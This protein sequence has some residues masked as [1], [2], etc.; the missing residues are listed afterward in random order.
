MGSEMCIRDSQQRY[1]TIELE[2][3]AIMWA[4]IK[5]N[6]YLKGLPHFSVLTDHKPLEGIFTKT[7]YELSNPRLRRRIREKVSGYTFSV[8]WVAGKT[9]YIADALS[10]APLF[11]PEDDP[12]M[13]VD[14]ALTALAITDD[15]AF[16]IIQ[17]NIDPD[18]IQCMNDIM[19][20]TERSSLIKKLSNIRKRLS[21][22]DNVILLD[23]V[24]I[25]PPVTAIK[26]ILS[27]LH[28]GHGGQEKTTTLVTGLFYWPGMHND[29]KT[30]VQACE[31]CF[32]RLPSQKSNP[33]VTQKP[34]V[35]FGPPM[36]QVALDLFDLAGKKH[37]ICVDRWSGFPVYK[38]L[39]SQ[40]TKAVTD[41]LSAWFNVLGWPST[42]RTD[43]S[44]IHI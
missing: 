32:K 1:A 35:S 19:G 21:V 30:F 29:I 12:D 28:A 39:Q 33:C 16:R 6:F 43:L 27:R 26:S 7:M 34:S 11:V 37:L 36:A 40:T 41:I 38:R 25:I 2:C 15:P 13:V 14:T 17:Q 42:I 10:R 3:L 44:L 23:S 18:Y 31:V 5:C 4:I 20:E 22:S 9:H 8:K 24:R